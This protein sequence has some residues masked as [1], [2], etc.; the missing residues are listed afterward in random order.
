MV[1]KVTMD[2]FEELCDSITGSVD[3]EDVTEE[4][5]ISSVLDS[6][7]YQIDPD[8]YPHVNLNKLISDYSQ[9]RFDVYRES[10]AEWFTDEFC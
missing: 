9:E 1:N 4:E 10:L 6:A 3:T 2:E 7:K 5:Y 8:K